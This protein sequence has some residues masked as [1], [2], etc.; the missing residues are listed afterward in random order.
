MQAADLFLLTSDTEGI[1]RVILEAGWLGLPVVSTR[2]GGIA[3]FVWHEETG[4][5]V[6]P[7]NETELAQAIVRLLRSCSERYQL[8][9]RAKALIQAN[10]TI[11]KI[12]REYVAFYRQVQNR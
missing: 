3:E 2:V 11:D 10:F 4:L 8:G 5:L 1:P 9:Q 6:A 7:E 12:A